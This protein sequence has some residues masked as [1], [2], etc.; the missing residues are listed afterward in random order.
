M[1]R[2]VR[3]GGL[4]VALGALLLTA[5][6]PGDSAAPTGSPTGT[7]TSPATG[8]TSASGTTGATPGP[9]SDAGASSSGAGPSTPDGEQLSGLGRPSAAELAAARADVAQLSDEQLVG[10]LVVGGYG[11]TDPAGAAQLVSRYHL[12]GVITLGGNVPTEPSQRVASLTAMSEQV[13]AAVRDDG[14]DWPAFVGIDQEGGPITRV[15]APLD[16][17]PAAMALG[18]AGDPALAQEVAQASGEQLR[19]LGYTVVFAPDADVTAGAQ[20]PTIGARSPGSEPELVADIAAGAA[21]G[22]A[23][24]GLVPVAKHFPGHGTVSA[25][26]HLG[27]AVQEADLDTLRTRDLVPFQTLVDDGIPAVMTAHIEVRAIDPD[28]PASLSKDVT[29]GL[30]RDEMGFEGIVVT[31]ALNMG[32]V[33]DV[34]GTAGV[35]P[36]VLAITAGAD[37]LLMPPDPGA[38][39]DALLA[40]LDDG[41]LTRDR[42]EGSAALVVATLRH[43]DAVPV[44]DPDVIGSGHDLAVRAAGAG[45]TQLS[46]DCGAPLVGDAIQV[47]GGT[48][49]SRAALEDA[50]REAGLTVGSG[51]VVVLLGGSEYQAGGGAGGPGTGTGDVVVS[52]DVPYALADSRADS[53]LIAAYGQD[54]ATMEALVPV[55]TGEVTAPGRLPVA[56]GTDH[57]IGSGCR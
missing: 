1:T 54:A 48:A 15:G 8:T 5:C 28:A 9:S 20:D 41:T 23:Q 49:A 13:H 29:T 53:A 11:G 51:D 56:V 46:G 18:A 55:L 16:R 44:P 52:T 37:V 17:W 21:A 42:V 31:D 19:A 38:T 4:A 39:V 10:Q 26:T 32:A 7:A 14:R 3:A 45:I 57:P 12:A 6:S 24:A 25:D 34:A 27:A 36:G 2:A 50:A 40:A 47:R 35:D 43:A 30:L 22:F 33:T